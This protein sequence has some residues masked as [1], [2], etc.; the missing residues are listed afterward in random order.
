MFSSLPGFSM[1]QGGP[2]PCFLK[3]EQLQTLLNGQYASLRESERQFQSGLA[4]FGLIELVNRKPCF[5]FL[6]RKTAVRPLMYPRV[7]KLLHAHFSVEGSNSRA[8]EEKVYR[9]FINYLRE[10]SGK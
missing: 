8:E 7:V 2:L 6:L 5:I 4:K 1:L 10:V 9:T 3:E